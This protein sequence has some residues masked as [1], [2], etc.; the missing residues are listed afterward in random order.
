MPHDCFHSTGLH[1][2]SCSLLFR[3]RI[4]LCLACQRQIIKKNRHLPQQQP[5]EHHSPTKTYNVDSLYYI[6]AGIIPPC[7]RISLP[8]RQSVGGKMRTLVIQ[9]C[10]VTPTTN[11]KPPETEEEL[12]SC[13]PTI[14]APVTATSISQVI[15]LSLNGGRP[16]Q[17]TEKQYP[18]KLPSSTNEKQTRG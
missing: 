14:H 8:A 3:F 4:F 16:Q 18:A 11:P 7:I 5:Q 17:Q 9:V 15:K 10:T 2:Y 6:L 13:G 1:N 12:P